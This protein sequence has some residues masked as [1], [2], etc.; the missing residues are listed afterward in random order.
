MRVAEARPLTA[1]EIARRATL[2]PITDIA[3]Q[4]GLAADLLEPYG[5]YVAKIKLD[6]DR[7]RSPTGRWPATWW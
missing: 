2:K 3:G 4:I 1:L 6:A 7:R 5:E